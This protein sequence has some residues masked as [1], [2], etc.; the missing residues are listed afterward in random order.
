MRLSRRTPRIANNTPSDGCSSSSGDRRLEFA[1]WKGGLSSGRLLAAW[2]SMARGKARNSGG[3]GSGRRGGGEGGG[4]SN[5]ERRRASRRSVRASR[6][7]ATA[8]V[9]TWATLPACLTLLSSCLVLFFSSFQLLAFQSRASDFVVVIEITRPEIREILRETLREILRETTPSYETKRQ[10]ADRSRARLGAP[11]LLSQ[12]QG[13]A[14]HRRW[15]S[16]C[17]TR[18]NIPIY[19]YLPLFTPSPRLSCRFFEAK[20][21]LSKCL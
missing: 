15:V 19:L 2:K 17:R 13:P 18:S 6:P 5:I 16:P 20:D 3:W 9:T 7:P 4:R 1:S 8:P 10:Y 11:V 21:R 14:G 12:L